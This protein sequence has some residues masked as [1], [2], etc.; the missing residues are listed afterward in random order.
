MF[1][2]REAVRAESMR[3]SGEEEGGSVGLRLCGVC[4]RSWPVAQRRVRVCSSAHAG[5]EGAGQRSPAA[6]RRGE[7]AR[8]E[9][10]HRHID[11]VKRLSI[12]PRRRRLLEKFGHHSLHRPRTHTWP[13]RTHT[14]PHTRGGLFEARGGLFRTVVN[15]VLG[16][17]VLNSRGYT[18][19]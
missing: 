1:P 12:N 16:P 18:S 14:W 4:A 9:V 6:A 8:A 10:R 11:A 3:A 7:E 17:T 15:S 13:H 19:T 2:Y 5:G